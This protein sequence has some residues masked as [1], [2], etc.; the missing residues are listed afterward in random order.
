MRTYIK[1]IQSKPEYIR[2]QI[3]YGSLIVSMVFVGLVWINGLGYKFNKNNKENITKEPKPFS[4]F[5]NSISETYNNITASV[6]NISNT[7]KNKN[8][9]NEDSIKEKQVDLIPV[10]VVNQ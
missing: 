1:K 9:V 6:G 8:E 3:L 2:K 5:G 4:L 10:E 7:L